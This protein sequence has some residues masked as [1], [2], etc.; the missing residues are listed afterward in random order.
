VRGRRIPESEV[1]S[2]HV[3]RREPDGGWDDRVRKGHDV[4][5]RAH[6]ER[7]YH[8]DLGGQEID[9]SGMTSTVRLEFVEPAAFDVSV[10]DVNQVSTPRSGERTY[11]APESEKSSRS[12]ALRGGRS[13]RPM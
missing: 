13:S 9:G 2:I 6:E 5:R 3:H 7:I 8:R 4:N 12:P 11:V 1:L 10:G